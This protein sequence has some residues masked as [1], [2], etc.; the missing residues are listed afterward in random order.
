MQNPYRPNIDHVRTQ[1]MARWEE[2]IQ[3]EKSKVAAPPAR[4]RRSRR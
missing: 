2:S 3:E 4:R 1:A